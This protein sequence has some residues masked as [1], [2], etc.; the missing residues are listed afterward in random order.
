[1]IQ[2]KPIKKMKIYF[3]LQLLKTKVKPTYK[4]QKTY[5]KQ[6]KECLQEMIFWAKTTMTY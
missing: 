1:M 5:L 2:I 3:L 4:F 6:E